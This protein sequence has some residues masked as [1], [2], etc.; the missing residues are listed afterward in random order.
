MM[1]SGQNM[2][3]ILKQRHG[4][5]PFTDTLGISFHWDM[6]GILRQ[7]DIKCRVESI[8]NSATYAIFVPLYNLFFSIPSTSFIFSRVFSFPSISFIFSLVVSFL[9]TSFV[10][11]CVIFFPFPSLFC[12][13][14]CLYIKY[15]VSLKHVLLYGA[16]LHIRNVVNHVTRTLTDLGSIA[17]AEVKLLLT[18]HTS[19]G[20]TK[21]STIASIQ[22]YHVRTHVQRDILS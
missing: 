13:C 4:G 21:K 8:S 6:G 11:S 18:D 16:M 5:Y 1:V 3:D 12:P 2:G 14:K 17:S 22:W 20:Q 9:S 7:R 15:G 19:N 10:L